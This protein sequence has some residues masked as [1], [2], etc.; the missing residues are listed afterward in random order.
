MSSDEAWRV[1]HVLKGML[2]NFGPAAGTNSSQ[3]QAS[4]SLVELSKLDQQVQN[5][6]GTLSLDEDAFETATEMDIDWVSCY[7][8]GLS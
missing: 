1:Y 8:L 2:S 3:S 7:H 4:E 5:T 6:S